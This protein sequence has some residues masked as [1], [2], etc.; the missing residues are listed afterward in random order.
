MEFVVGENRVF[1]EENGEVLAEIEFEKI[2]EM[3]YNI[4]HTF[5]DERLRG[6]GVASKLVERAVQEIESR[7]GKVVASCSYAKAWLERK[8]RES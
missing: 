1:Y 2:D 8:G 4:Y 3:T 5:V 6:K 7:N